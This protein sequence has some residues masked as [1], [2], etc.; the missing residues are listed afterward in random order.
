LSTAEIEAALV[1]YQGVAE[2]A[3]V[4]TADE[5][6]GQCIPWPLIFANK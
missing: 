5:L 1:M 2:A 4:G 6:T 3:V